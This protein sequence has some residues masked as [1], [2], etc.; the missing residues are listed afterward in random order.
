[1]PKKSRAF[2]KRPDHTQIITEKKKMNL[3]LSEKNPE[4][5]RRK[6]GP[7]IQALVAQIRALPPSPDLRRAP[8][9]AVR[10]LRRRSSRRAGSSSPR[11][12]T[13]RGGGRGR[14]V[15]ARLHGLLARIRQGRAWAEAWRGW[16]VAL[17]TGWIP[18]CD[19]DGPQLS[20]ARQPSPS[21]RQ[22]SS[23][24]VAASRVG[25]GA[26]EIEDGGGSSCR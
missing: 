12:A 3:I 1:M 16:A 15:G 20:T 22:S 18:W 24:M 19:G 13:A 6:E 5:L 17:A 10:G 25:G 14:A 2:H 11:E 21:R 4:K 7:R 8:G 23:P 9:A 26:A